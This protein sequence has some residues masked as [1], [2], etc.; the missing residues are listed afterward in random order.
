LLAAFTA[1]MD[2][3]LE[4]VRAP[5]DALAERVAALE[6]DAVD[7]EIIAEYGERLARMERMLMALDRF[8]RS[9]P[10]QGWHRM[11]DARVSAIEERLAMLEQ[12]NPRSGNHVASGDGWRPSVM[13]VETY[14]ERS[15]D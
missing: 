2:Q 14:T 15:A 6:K 5:Y 7:P 10:G 11:H 12:E 9:L 13:P 8:A 3:Q 4:A 1:F